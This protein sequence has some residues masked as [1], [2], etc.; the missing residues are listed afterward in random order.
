MDLGIAG[1]VAV[2][3]G[4][5]HGIGR[6]IARGLSNEGVRVAI[7]GRTKE[8]LMVAAEGI[9]QQTGNPV[10]PVVAD[11]LIKQ[12]IENF[13]AT[14]LAEFGSVDIAVN[15]ADLITHDVSFFELYDEDWLEKVNIKLLAPIRMIQ[16][17]APVMRRNGWG[18]IINIGGGSARSVNDGSWAK[19]A[20]QPGLINLT[21]RL[22]QLL[23]HD[24]ITVN[25][26][27]PGNIWTDGRTRAGGRSRI[28]VRSEE[29]AARAAAEG[30]SYDEMEERACR[31]FVI[32]RRL[33]PED[34]AN[35]VAYL[36]SRLA[37]AITGETLLVDGGEKPTVRF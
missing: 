10:L 30:I 9:Q 23:G 11:V 13:V 6:A 27:E 24:G 4:G 36:S 15:N 5:S 19:G 28:E 17:V 29:L 26:V 12:D 20:T 32:G 3:T 21:K 14:T 31:E 18:R 34:V 16:L 7:C 22:S 8:S 37:G 1:K 33:Q 25:L 35:L 2:V